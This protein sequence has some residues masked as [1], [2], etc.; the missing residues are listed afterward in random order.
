M[1]HK[2]HK[3]ITRIRQRSGLVLFARP[4]YH[5]QAFLDGPLTS[6]DIISCPRVPHPS[7]ASWYTINRSY[8]QARPLSPAWLHLTTSLECL[9]RVFF[10][11]PVSLFPRPQWAPPLSMVTLYAI[12][13]WLARGARSSGNLSGPP[14]PSKLV[15][16]NARQWP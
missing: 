16:Q 12:L 3:G 8:R 15:V 5:E 14:G 11:L 7:K 1:S 2:H 6:K 10:L 4:A 9:S 13:G